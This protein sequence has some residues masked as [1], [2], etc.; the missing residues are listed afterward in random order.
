MWSSGSLLDHFDNGHDLINLIPR[1]S[2]KFSVER[3]LVGVTNKALDDNEHLLQVCRTA[4]A[5]DINS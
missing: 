2:Q 1:F 3:K 5:I 4:I